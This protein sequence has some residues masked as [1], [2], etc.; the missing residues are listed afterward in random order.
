MNAG[1]VVFPPLS[2]PAAPEMSLLEQ[3][4]IK[5]KHVFIHILSRGVGKYTFCKI[6]W[7]YCY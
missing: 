4:L 6:L 1:P 2:A 3:Q 7:Q 5:E